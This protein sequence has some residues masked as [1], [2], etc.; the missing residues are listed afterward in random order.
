MRTNQMSFVLL[1]AA[2]FLDSM[3]CRLVADLTEVMR[4]K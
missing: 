3:A 1:G 2:S 4:D